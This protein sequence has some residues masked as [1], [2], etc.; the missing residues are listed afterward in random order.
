MSKLPDIDPLGEKAKARTTKLAVNYDEDRLDERDVH[1]IQFMKMG[2]V[3]CQK[4]NESSYLSHRDV[5]YVNNKRYG[6]SVIKQFPRI[7]IEPRRG[8]K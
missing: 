8:K 7:V 4:G 1:Y 5:Y 3:F 2:R 6:E